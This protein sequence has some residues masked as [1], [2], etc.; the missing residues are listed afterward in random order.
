MVKSSNSYAHPFN[1]RAL[2][3]TGLFILSTVSILILSTSTSF[4]YSYREQLDSM[5]YQ[6]IGR[7][8][9]NG[10]LPYKDLWDL[11]GPLIFFINALGFLLTDSRYGILIFQII[12]L[13]VSLLFVSYY[14]RKRVSYLKAFVGS[15]I[16]C[17][18]LAT[19][20]EGGNM[21]EEYILPFLYLS[22]I[23]MNC[24]I[25]NIR[26]GNYEHKWVYG[27]VY[28]LTFAFALYT[29]LTNALPLCA[30]IAYISIFLICKRKWINL[31]YNMLAFIAGF[32]LIV[33]P[34]FVYFCLTDT[35]LDYWA[36]IEFCFKYLSQSNHTLDLKKLIF[37]NFPIFLLIIVVFVNYLYTKH[38]HKLLF[39][40][41]V[42]FVSLYW[43]INS[44]GFNHYS[45]IF[46]PYMLIS[47]YEIVQQSKRWQLFLFLVVLLYIV[48]GVKHDLTYYHELDDVAKSNMIINE[49]MNK[50][51]ETDRGNTLIYCD[52][53]SPYLYQ[54]ICPSKFFYL[55]DENASISSY[56]KEMMLAD[57]NRVR[58]KYVLTG[59]SADN[60][61]GILDSSYS[62][63]YEEPYAK[64]YKRLY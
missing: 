58:P 55:Q 18:T 45:I 42:S 64:T 20:Y 1:K 34:F 7:E 13:F 29:R 6:V 56:Y 19:V 10:V 36:S 16:I 43:V 35:I 40:S 31:L 61:N 59:A 48:R 2:L 50:V 63:L 47:L 17:C 32:L 28:G 25:D 60:I 14:L 57:F 62:L 33:V 9:L 51:P 39:W 53:I 46:L 12:F 22:F 15:L 52:I 24:W 49:M 11:K 30:G 27:L 38:L 23:C 8:W 21:V 4:F 26:E 41:L 44:R 5:V 37:F 3:I 54:G